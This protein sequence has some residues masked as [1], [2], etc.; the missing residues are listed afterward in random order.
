MSVFLILYLCLTRYVSQAGNLILRSYRGPNQCFW[1]YSYS[2]LVL[3]QYK[4][5]SSLTAISHERV[6]R[7]LDSDGAVLRTLR[8]AIRKHS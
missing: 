4:T 3:Q 6:S 5:H 8:C 2:T 7:K 1:I